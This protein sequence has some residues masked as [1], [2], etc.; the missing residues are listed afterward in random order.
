MPGNLQSLLQ[1]YIR[2][3]HTIYGDHL[4]SVLLYGSYARGDFRPDSDIDLMILLDMS[5]L[6]IKNY[7]HDLSRMN[8]DFNMDHDVEINPI[9]KSL[10]HFNIWTNTYPFY[11]AVKKE[12]VPLYV[13][14]S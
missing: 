14:A 9:A 6:E 4:K 10:D 12:G 13:S 2:Q 11:H 7:R 8:F 1:Q 3:L 5:D